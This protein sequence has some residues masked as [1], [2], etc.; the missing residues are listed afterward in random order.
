MLSRAEERVRHFYRWETIGRGWHMYTKPCH[1]EPTFHPF[2]PLSYA[3][4]IVDDGRKHTWVSGLISKVTDTPNTTPVT[5]E[6]MEHRYRKAQIL[7][8]PI[9]IE[10]KLPKAGNPQ[11]QVSLQFIRLLSRGHPVSFEVITKE[12]TITSRFVVPNSVASFITQQARMHFPDAFVSQHTD[13]DIIKTIDPMLWY[14]CIDLGLRHE[15][16][17]PLRTL[18]PKSIDHL[19]SIIASLKSLRKNE[20]GLVQ[21]LFQPVEHAW[22]QEIRRSVSDGDGGCFFEDA[23]FMLKLAEEKSEHPLYAV[24]IRVLAIS[25]TKKRSN[26]LGMELSHSVIASTNSRH[27]SLLRL[28]NE[29]H[30]TAE[31]IV[32]MQLRLSRRP[33]MILNSKELAVLVHP[34]YIADSIIETDTVYSAIPPSVL[35]HSYILGTSGPEMERRE[36]GLS[37]Q[38]RLRHIHLIGASGSGKST[39]LHRLIL[40]DIRSGKGCMVLDPHGD[41]I[42]DVMQY[43]PSE[44]HDDI[45]LIDPSDVEYPVGINIL[46]AK[47]EAEKMVLSSDL[48][49]LFRRLSSSWGVQM[50]TVFANAIAA[51]LESY[52]GGTLLDLKRFLVE[53]D[54]RVSFLTTVQDPATVYYWEKE[55]PTLRKNAFGPVLTRLDGFLRSKIV[56]N[57]MIQRKGI[58]F[59]SLVA[60]NKVILVKLSHGLIGKENSYLLG[61]MLVS[62]LNQVM[63]AKQS[64]QRS[65]RSPYFLYIDE[66]QN[67]I[68]QSLEDIL[69]G[70]RKYGLGLV[71]AHQYMHQIEQ[72]SKEVAESVI[73]NVGTRIC[74]RLGETDANKLSKGF[75]HFESDDLKKLPVGQAIARVGQ[76]TDDF[77]LSCALPEGIS[78]EVGAE[79]M[80]SITMLSR[81]KFGG[82]RGAIE[83]EYVKMYN[84]GSSSNPLQV[85]QSNSEEPTD[86]SDE[87]P[88][89]IDIVNSDL[90][91][92]DPSTITNEVVVDML[93]KKQ[94]RRLHAQLQREI[95]QKAES[96][97]FKA[98]IEEEMPDGLGRVDVGLSRESLRIACE[99]SVTTGLQHDIEKI[100]RCLVCQYDH[101]IFISPKQN[102]LSRIRK[103]CHSKINATNLDKISFSSSPLQKELFDQWKIQNTGESAKRFKGFRV[104]VSYKRNTST[105]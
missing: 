28:S 61:T 88:Q 7:D 19:G 37:L 25:N 33:G 50:H 72:Q 101:I 34:G 27:N 57:M 23:P 97:G 49:S 69:S 46:D 64:Q 73:A 22:A 6:K 81:A 3:P 45:V 99:V 103:M 86:K 41:L 90:G 66:F 76:S 102:Y 79:N 75:A 47:S 94:E 24:C 36:V 55:F 52:Q 78:D 12:E 38:Q 53:E 32:E 59:S 26:S 10:V 48:I 4:R 42:E 21:I 14:T 58:D 89:V 40:D 8:N 16:M 63:Q 92:S 67:F 105:F 31:H 96:L 70:A 29:G 20:T 95:K 98:V 51:F 68:T 44:R 65:K 82:D 13:I 43:I 91:D 87:F 62:K 5:Q 60:Q 100:E 9:G 74:Y 11:T 104:T 15:F 80:K 71:I 30:P 77:K 1:L 85:E 83:Q 35:G 56:R 93:S 18:E 17:C 2:E 84:S 39:L 54:F